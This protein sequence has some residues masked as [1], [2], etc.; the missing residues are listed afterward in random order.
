[1]GVKNIA[2]L[3]AWRIA[4][5]CPKTFWFEFWAPLWNR[6]QLLAL[7]VALVGT[8]L[9]FQTASPDRVIAE[10][11][12]WA[13]SVKAFGWALVVWAG[14]MAFRTPFVAMKRERELGRWHG[15]R[16]VY[17]EPHLVATLR[18]KA[19]GQ[20]Q[21]HKVKFSDAEPSSFVYYFIEVEGNPPIKLYT[22]SL[23]SS[24]VKSSRAEPGL[25]PQQGGIRIGAD[26]CAE[27][28]IVMRKDMVS[29]TVRIYMRDFSLLNPEDQ[30]GDE[31]EFRGPFRR[32]LEGD[33][34]R[35]TT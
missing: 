3:R 8:V 25:G 9:I 10:A 23:V 6:D 30:D 20:P 14:I 33:G 16:F 11:T 34:G 28:L 22:A 2:A 1:M 31:G 26:R 27:L 17:R 32:P 29:Q 13:F 15:R 24:S 7:I 12:D 21:F 5:R 19:T 35:G 4:K 18:C